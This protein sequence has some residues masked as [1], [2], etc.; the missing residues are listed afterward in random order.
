MYIIIISYGVA[1]YCIYSISVIGLTSARSTCMAVVM[2]SSHQLMD[3]KWRN[4]RGG[5]EEAARRRAMWQ[6]GCRRQEEESGPCDVTAGHNT[7]QLRD[8]KGDLERMKAHEH[9]RGNEDRREYHA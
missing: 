1:I 3:R 9:G 6:W 5:G 7:I 4:G 2:I 8:W